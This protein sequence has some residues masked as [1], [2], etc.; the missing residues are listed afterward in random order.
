MGTL[1]RFDSIWISALAVIAG[2]IVPTITALESRHKSRHDEMVN[3][4]DRYRDRLQQTESEY[5]SLRKKYNDLETKYLKLKVRFD[6]E[7]KS[8]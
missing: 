8:K 4:I 2:T 1:P 3:D 7:N 6:D 5:D